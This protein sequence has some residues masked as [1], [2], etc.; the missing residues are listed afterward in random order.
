MGVSWHSRA[1]HH[2]RVHRCAVMHSNAS[3][4]TSGSQEN[5]GHQT[6]LHS[7]RGR[8]CPTCVIPFRK[9]DLKW[10]VVCI[11]LLG[12]RLIRG[13]ACSTQCC[14]RL[15]RAWDRRRRKNISRKDVDMAG[16]GRL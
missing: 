6:S 9:W 15:C 8:R 11:H 3:R 7:S 12:V 5:C 10:D 13:I 16:R 2:L 1:T 4:K 14:R